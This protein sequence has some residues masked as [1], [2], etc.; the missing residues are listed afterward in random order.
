MGIVVGD[1]SI[2]E[3]G[4]KTGREEILPTGGEL[5]LTQEEKEV[6]S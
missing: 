6:P 3:G 1:I 2:S 4:N 5:S